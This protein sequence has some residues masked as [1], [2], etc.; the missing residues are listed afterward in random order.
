M[1]G[2]ARKNTLVG[3]GMGVGANVAGA[4]RGGWGEK[5]DRKIWKTK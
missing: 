5:C 3:F 2:R 1:N 4:C